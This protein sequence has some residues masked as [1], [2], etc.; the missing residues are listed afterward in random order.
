MLT[1][2]IN[3]ARGKLRVLGYC[4]GSGNTLWK[5]YEL[6]KQLEQTPEGSPF[7]IVGI[8]ADKPD[9][10]AVA[11]AQAYGVPYVAVDIRQYYADRNKPLKDREVRAE[12]DREVLEQVEQ[13]QADMILLA[14]YVWATT[15]AVLDRYTVVN[16]H[17]ADLAVTG[18][19]GHRLL[20]GANGIKSAFSYDMDYLR[21]SS[22]IAT[23]ELDAG[24]LLVRSPKVPVDYTLHTDE[25]ERFRYYLKLVNEQARLVGA[26]TVLE[27]ALGNFT[28]DDD[29]HL[30]YK[31]APAPTGLCFESWEENKP[32]FERDRTKLFYPDSVAVIGASSRPGMGNAIVHNMLEL[33]YTGRLYAVNRKAEPVH[34]V[35]GY[36]SVLDIP[37]TIDTAVLAVPSGG[38]LGVAEECGRKGVK[39]MICITAGFREV[40]GEGV[41][42]ERKL[43][44]IVDRYNMCM[45]GPNCM[46][47]ANTSDRVRLSATILDKSP[48]K[49]HVA[50]LT[51][52]GAL[53][54]S[55]IDFADELDVGFSVVVSLGNMANTNPC[56][57]LPMLE[58]DENTRIICMYMETL[59]EPYRFERVM[60]GITK[61]VI[62]V[63]SGRTAA[64]AKAASSH[65]GSLAC[66]DSVA[67]ALL[68]KCGVIRAENL[69][70][71]F[72]LASAMSKMPRIRGNRVGIISNA[73]GLGTLTTDVLVKYGFT[74]PELSAEEQAAL[75]PQLLP[76]ASTHNPLDLVAPAPPAHYAAAAHAMIDSGR[77]DAIIVDCVPPALVDTGEVAQ[78]MVDILK[79]TDIPIFSCFFGPNL[80]ARGRKVMKEGGIP[81]F[82][83]PD[84]MVRTMAYMVEKPK[85]PGMDHAPSLRLDERIEAREIMARTAPGTYLTPDDCFRLLSLY[86]VPVAANAYLAC[87]EDPDL[88][89]IPYPVV[90]KVDHPDIIHKSDVGG[91][92][93]NLQNAG[94]LRE[95][96]REWEVKFPGLRG[97][98]IQ[99]QV[100]GSLEMIIGASEDP[101]LG[102]SILTGLGGTLVEVL[103]DV[104]FGHVPLSGTDAE[105]MLSTL[106]CAKLLDGYRGSKGIDREAFKRIL[107][108]VNDLLLDFPEIAEMDINP[109][110]FDAD[111]NAFFAVDARIRLN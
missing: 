68:R 59:P 84:Q 27:L 5:A 81:T 45:T 15:D 65:T 60:K 100:R 34:G 79:S 108:G 95:L 63:K 38:V 71:A 50:F 17:P 61:P 49:G 7:E 107:Y 29:G 101:A 89:N 69:E 105:E 2:I 70:D 90:A 93:L 41:E 33:G 74:L 37:D 4:S 8:F 30:Y 57:L 102:H 86:G 76:E 96:M 94:Q 9:S 77:Y 88:L 22:H 55:L 35:L 111:R 85:L 66:N 75:A 42:R 12:F 106:Q 56:D 10:K 83:F 97:I 67:D 58:A 110:I 53:G 82:S 18:E 11:T 80:G 40:G 104:A 32:F 54:A 25:E 31:G 44:E 20:A 72:L 1:P 92:R 19:D 14:G 78:A 43:L 48:R 36:S 6:Q 39:A 47:L 26:R 23:K 109:L 51:Q 3:P 13:F 87:G 99:Q 46:G 21:A 28:V 62:M 16:V 103:K 24:P 52:S 73:G 64:G 91:V 98:Q